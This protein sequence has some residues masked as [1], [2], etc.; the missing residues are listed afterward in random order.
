MMN[1]ALSIALP[2][3]HRALGAGWKGSN[4]RLSFGNCALPLSYTRNACDNKGAATIM[5]L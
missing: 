2:F 4:L 1:I 5:K 3:R